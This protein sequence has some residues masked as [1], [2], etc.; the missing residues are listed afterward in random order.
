MKTWSL[1]TF[2][3]KETIRTKTMIAGLVISLL[4]LAFVPMLS[5]TGGSGVIIDDPETK[6]AAARNFLDFALGGLNFIGLFMAIFTTL[7]AIYTEVERGTILTVVTKPISRWQLIAGKWLGHV[8]I[9]ICYVLIMGLALW[10]S[11]AL[12]S[13]AIIWQ[14]FL[15]IAL[16]C[17]NVVTIVS[18]TLL[19]STFV[20]VVANAIFVFLIIVVTSN[21]RII[22]AIGEASHNAF[23]KG[24]A[25]ILR[26]AL[27]VGEVGDL[28][29][30]VLTGEAKAIDMAA[31]EAGVF[32]P[33]SWSFLYEI[34]YFS[35]LLLLAGYI[36]RKRDLKPV[37]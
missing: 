29:A 3:F 16:V 10:L 14:F 20:P 26:M 8:M 4:Y 24:A 27:P 1:A 21:M 17:L 30:M 34:V 9:M 22:N 13:G 11:V 7:G 18:L 33:R 37:P 19:F 35:V 36:F 25:S 12:G 32:S 5:S 28:A 15:S 31:A 2:T 6:T 23:L